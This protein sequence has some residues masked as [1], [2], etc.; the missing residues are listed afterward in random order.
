MLPADTRVSAK[1]G[2]STLVVRARRQ[3]ALQGGAVAGGAHPAA[4][5]RGGA[6]RTPANELHPGVEGTRGQELAG[7]TSTIVTMQRLQRLQQGADLLREVGLAHKQRLTEGM[8]SRQ[9]LD[10]DLPHA[11]SVW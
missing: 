4:G 9:L 5:Q 7:S 11:P 10:E 6:G 3:G 8:K 1:A 2:G